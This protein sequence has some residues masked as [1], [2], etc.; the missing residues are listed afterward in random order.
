LIV[1]ALLAFLVLRYDLAVDS[2]RALPGE[3]VTARA[4]CREVARS[5]AA[6]AY[7]LV[8]PTAPRTA[9][10]LLGWLTGERIL[11]DGGTRIDMAG[12]PAVLR[13]PVRARN[14]SDPEAED[15]VRCRWVRDRDARLFIPLSRASAVQVTVR[16]RAL[17]TVEPQFMGLDW[18][19][20][21]IGPQPMTTAWADYTF[22]VPAAAVREGT[23]ELVLQFERAPLYRRVRGQGPHEVRPAAI[24][25]ITLA[26]A[27]S[28]RPE[29]MR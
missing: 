24:A 26:R 10:G 15:G 9:A 6:D 14:F 13:L 12:D 3:P 7:R 18:N 27:D 11:E 19:G 20:T 28:S 17:E 16:A 22:A 21:S 1:P 23:N 4:A 5:L 25:S 29:Q 2:L 8:E